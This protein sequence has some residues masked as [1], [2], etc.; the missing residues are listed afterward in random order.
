MCVALLKTDQLLMLGK[1]SGG[2]PHGGLEEA[3]STTFDCAF[4][5]WQI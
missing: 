2:S 4:H 1:L 3:K 5:K